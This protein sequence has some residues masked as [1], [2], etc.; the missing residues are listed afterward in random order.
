MEIIYY[1]L[2]YLLVVLNLGHRVYTLLTKLKIVQVGIDVKPIPHFY[3]NVE[4]LMNY[5]KI[6]KENNLSKTILN[7][8]YT[9]FWYL[10]FLIW[11]VIL[12]L[13]VK[14]F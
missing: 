14:L 10:H 11:G 13:I 9:R 7:Y 2:A 4:L 8:L 3:L 12:F 5:H 6:K 1:I